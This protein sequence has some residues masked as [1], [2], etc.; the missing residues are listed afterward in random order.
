MSIKFSI[1]VGSRAKKRA[2]SHADE[3]NR[4]LTGFALAAVKPM[5]PIPDSPA[6]K[7]EIHV[8]SDFS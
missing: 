2:A 6:S 7:N 8:N 1:A 3:P 5:A 4:A